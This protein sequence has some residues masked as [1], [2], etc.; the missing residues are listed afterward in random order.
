MEKRLHEDYPFVESEILYS[1][2][3]EMAVKPNDIICR[4]VPVSFID[5]KTSSETVL[6]RVVEIMAKEL[7][8]SE[9]K[10]AK[11]LQEA[12]KGLSYMK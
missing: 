12:L 5:Q 6:P 7:K 8:W 10:K 9:E 2:Q 11:E 1:I 4:R 3:S